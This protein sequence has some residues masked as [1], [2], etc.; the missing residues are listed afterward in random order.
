MIKVLKGHCEPSWSPVLSELCRTICANTLA[1]AAHI[2]QTASTTH[3]I[4]GAMAEHPL[5]ELGSEERLFHN[6]AYQRSTLQHNESNVPMEITL[7]QNCHSKPQALW[8]S[9]QPLIPW[10]NDPCLHFWMQFN[11]WTKCTHVKY[12]NIWGLFITQSFFCAC[13]WMVLMAGASNSE[14]N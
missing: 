7:N 11:L 6:G 1:L 13:S 3:F 4:I 12:G 9:Y 8:F 2:A 14:E 5:P 10:S